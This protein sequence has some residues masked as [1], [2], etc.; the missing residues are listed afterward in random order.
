MAL[1][2]HESGIDLSGPGPIARALQLE[3][4]H[5]WASDVLACLSRIKGSHKKTRPLGVMTTNAETTRERRERDAGDLERDL[6]GLRDLRSIWIV[7]RPA[8]HRASK[9]PP[10]PT[11]SVIEKR[12][13]DAADRVIV[14][15]NRHEVGLGSLAIAAGKEPDSHEYRA[16]ECFWGDLSTA[17]AGLHV[18]PLNAQL[19]RTHG[20]TLRGRAKRIVDLLD[21]KAMKAQV[22][23]DRF[24]TKATVLLRKPG[25]GRTAGELWYLKHHGILRVSRKL[26][27]FY[28]PDA[29]PP[30]V[31][32]V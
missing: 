16:W 7:R 6:L 25:P 27:G 2:K 30:D 15:V 18:A 26:G 4:E 1:R 19:A 12:I 13:L 24:G 3:H 14:V 32:A 23:A 29:P 9:L 20:V 22:I 8:I 5:R 31:S 21:G 28:R 17:L 11:P 10:P